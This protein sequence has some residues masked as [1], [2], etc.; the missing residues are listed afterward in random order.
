MPSSEKTAL[1]FIHKSRRKSAI[2]SSLA[3]LAL[4][5]LFAYMKIMNDIVYN[6]DCVC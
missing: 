3:T 6:E 5:G 2:N 1:W 4:P